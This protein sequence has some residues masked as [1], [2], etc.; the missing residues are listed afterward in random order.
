MKGLVSK[1]HYRY[2]VLILLM[3]SS[4]YFNQK[5]LSPPPPS[6]DFSQILTPYL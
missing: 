6:Y 4:A 1:E 3:K 2:K 5:T